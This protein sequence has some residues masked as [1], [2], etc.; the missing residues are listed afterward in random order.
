MG[1]RALFGGPCRRV[2]HVLTLPYIFSMAKSFPGHQ[3]QWIIPEC[4]MWRGQDDSTAIWNNN[5]ISSQQTSFLEWSLMQIMC[6]ALHFFWLFPTGLC[7]D[8]GVLRAAFSF[9]LFFFY[10]LPQKRAAWTTPDYLYYIHRCKGGFS[11]FNSKSIT[12][13]SFSSNV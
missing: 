2:W 12:I 13:I 4:Y 10:F 8:S 7:N 11:I 5:K 3:T 9:F 1:K 6:P